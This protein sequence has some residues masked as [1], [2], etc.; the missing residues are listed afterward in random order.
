ME[1]DTSPEG[2]ASLLSKSFTISAK[3]VSILSESCSA[4]AATTSMARGIE[5]CNISSTQLCLNSVGPTKLMMTSAGG[6]LPSAF[7][8]P[9]P[10]LYEKPGIEHFSA[11]PSRHSWRAAPAMDL[12]TVTSRRTL[13][14]PRSTFSTVISETPAR[15]ETARAA[16]EGARARPARSADGGGTRLVRASAALAAIASVVFVRGRRAK[17]RRVCEDSRERRGF[18]GGASRGRARRCMRRGGD[19]NRSG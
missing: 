11:K 14:S 3:G 7:L 6:S 9:P 18:G 1:Y 16:R 12:G 17:G 19:R 2:S 8:R 5:R 10:F 13:Q 15:T 4:V